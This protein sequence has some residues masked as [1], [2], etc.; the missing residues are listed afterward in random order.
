MKTGL[1]NSLVFEPSIILSEGISAILH[2]FDFCA[3]NYR[4]ATIEEFS[5]I[6]KN[7]KVDIAIVNP[8]MIQNRM[9]FWRKI[10][11]IYPDIRW[12]GVAT[13]V[14]DPD[15]ESFYNHVF[16]LYTPFNDIREILLKTNWDSD[17]TFGN[18]SEM[19]SDRETEVLTLLI[20][21]CTNKEIAENLNISVHTV[22]SHRKN[23]VVKTGIKSQAGLT[24][25]AISNNIVSL[26]EFS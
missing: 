7:K 26:E 3:K 2:Q 10:K 23:I 22:I 14:L 11:R 25:Y 17:D 8:A 19:L 15:V 21:G 16:S 12:M 6:I 20:K 1:L 4:A 9:Q 18:D 13:Y 5:N 24:I